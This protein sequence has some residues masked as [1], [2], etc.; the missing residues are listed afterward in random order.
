MN[1]DGRN[2]RQFQKLYPA[3]RAGW[4]NIPPGLLEGGLQQT[5]NLSSK[6]TTMVPWKAAIPSVSRCAYLGRE[7]GGGCGRGKKNGN[8][9]CKSSAWQR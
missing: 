7:E 4:R 9:K 5:P 1:I 8:Q 3:I 2:G 6:P